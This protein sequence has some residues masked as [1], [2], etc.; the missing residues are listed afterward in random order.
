[1]LDIDG[2]TKISLYLVLVFTLNETQAWIQ[3]NTDEKTQ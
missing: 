3:T 2:I 1:M